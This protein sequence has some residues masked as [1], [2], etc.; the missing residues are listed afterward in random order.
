[1]SGQFFN[2]NNPRILMC[3]PQYFG[4]EYS[5]NDWMNTTIL[6]Q[7]D[8]AQS[9]WNSLYS[10]IIELGAKVELVEPIAGQPDMTYVDVGLVYSNI[11]ITSNFKFPERQ[12]E[13]KGFVKWFE[14]NRF[15]IFEFENTISFEGHGDTLWKDGHTLFGGYG[16]RTQLE[17]YD[18]IQ[19]IL[20]QKAE[21]NF[22]KNS[23]QDSEKNILTKPKIITLE[24]IDSR[25]YHL[26][27]CFCPI[28]S[29]LA[30]CYT[31]A[32]SLESIEKIR[33]VMEIVEVDEDEAVHFACNALPI[34]NNLILPEGAPKLM[35]KLEELGFV[36]H[37]VPMSEF[38][39]GGG[40]C[41]CLSMPLQ[42]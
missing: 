22:T 7:Y 32:L 29:D 30:L 38:I 18:Y 4:I 39:K 27:T 37:P 15:N 8:L 35:S 11:F 41:K 42:V 6:S 40:A 16:F 3:P 28:R 9:Q 33:S 20:D 24:L 31:K 2:N 1:M 34:G 23:E 10:K 5:I 17:S 26:D 14:V 12:G 19:K 36:C 21:Q 25:F 13:K